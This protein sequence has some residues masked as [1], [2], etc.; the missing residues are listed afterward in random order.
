MPSPR[1]PSRLP[2]KLLQVNIVFCAIFAAVFGSSTAC[3]AA[4]GSIVFP[5]LRK[6]KY[7]G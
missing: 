7:K 6:R 4:V 1:F 2:G 5:E 3:A